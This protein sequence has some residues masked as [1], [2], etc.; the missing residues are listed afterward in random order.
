MLSFPR[1]LTISACSHSQAVLCAICL[2]HKKRGSSLMFVD[3]QVE[4]VTF[5]LLGLPA[6]LCLL[7]FACCK[8]SRR[9]ACRQGQPALMCDVHTC[10]ASNAAVAQMVCAAE[11]SDEV[12]THRPCVAQSHNLCPSAVIWPFC[13]SS[14]NF[15]CHVQHVKRCLS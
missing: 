4:P 13:M 9:S 14:L 3:K 11:T 10:A 15:A 7:W 2:T 12:V 6:V 1:P 5:E 8:S